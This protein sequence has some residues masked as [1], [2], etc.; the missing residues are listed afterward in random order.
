MPVPSRDEIRLSIFGSIDGLTMF[1]GLVAGVIISRQANSAIWHAAL[2]GAMGEFAGM[3][4]GQYM[5]D[6]ASGLS[7][8]VFCGAAG[9]VAC[10]APAIPFIFLARTPAMVTAAVI[11]VVIAALISW[12]RPEHG[13]T[14]VAETYGVLL[15]AGILSGLTGLI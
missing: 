7:A 10:S 13:W 1:L 11:A 2:G 12:L 8:A 3:T 4:S 6:K 14:A 9:A 15:A 5:S